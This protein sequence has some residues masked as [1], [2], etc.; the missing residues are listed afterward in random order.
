MEIKRVFDIL[1]LYNNEYAELKD[2]FSYKEKGSWVNFSAQDYYKYSHLF[3]CGLINKG[4]KKGEK[5]ITMSQSLPHWNIADMGISLAGLVNVPIYTTLGGEELEYILRH[6]DAKIIIVSDQNLYKKLKPIADK[7]P[8]I[9]TVFTFHHIEGIENWVSLIQE[10]QENEEELMKKL[11]ERKKS[12]DENDMHTLI[13]TSG[14][15]GNPKGVMI[16]HKNILSNA[17]AVKPI[18]PIDHGQRALSFLPL[19]HIYER[20]LNYCFQIKGI[21]IYYA[22]NLGTIAND[23]KDIKP[24][25]FNSV[26]RVLEKFYDRIISVGK[27]LKGIKK[28]IFFAAVRLGTKYDD[29]GKNS[30]M[31]RF[32]LGIYRKLVFNKWKAALGGNI[33]A[34]VSGGASLQVRLA[35]LYTAAGI[36]ICEGYG[37]TETSPVLA[38]N[39]PDWNKS[40]LG[41]VGPILEG[42]QVKIAEG[43]KEILAK[44]P[45]IMLGYYKNEEETK[46]VIDEDGWFHT[47]DIG[48]FID[49]KYLKITDRIKE[50]FK[51]SSG[52]YIAPQV[53]EN[54]F[55]TSNLIEQLMV[56]GENEKFVSALIS[57]NFNYLHF[58][59]SKHK[60]HYRENSDLIK[61][62]EIINKIQKEINLVNETLGEHERIKRFRLVCEEWSQQTGEL[63]PTLKLKRNV[64]YKKYAHILEEIYGHGED[65]TEKMGKE[66]PGPKET[67][68]KKISNGMKKLI[69][70]YSS[71]KE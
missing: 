69:N 17:L 40:R 3:A 28:W 39:W 21:S 38:V 37:L 22:E 66:G 20:M 46:K 42:V 14:T 59:A 24:H 34:V 13:Y 47:G 33:V 26:P 5:I 2:A 15:T 45:N 18:V 65:K 36:R 57:P 6:S 64:I 71:N 60:I 58:Y 55:K 56:V 10:A 53:I 54:K 70:I 16:S 61:H 68:E 27:D 44:G 63:S 8:E 23:L 19:C 30:L 43:S 31:Y 25:L 7:I 67:F 4:F 41:T 9:Q 51:T 62:S 49:N 1:E 35:R 52:K 48:E 12:V 29:K 11:E 50:T 32:K